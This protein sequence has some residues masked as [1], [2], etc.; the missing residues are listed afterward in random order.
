MKTNTLADKL[1]QDVAYVLEETEIAL[2]KR[3]LDFN[4]LK[5]GSLTIEEA[6]FLKSL[7]HEVITESAEDFIPDDVDTIEPQELA[8]AIPPEEA[9]EVPQEEV[10][11]EDKLLTDENGVIYKWNA[12]TG[13]LTPADEPT[14]ELVQSELTQDNSDL[15]QSPDPLA[16]QIDEATI[17]SSLLRF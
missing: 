12:V 10:P 3:L 13:D 1:T 6:E 14:E 7:V 11:Q 15:E 2:T 16:V 5:H 8:Q 9:P 4:L 17:A